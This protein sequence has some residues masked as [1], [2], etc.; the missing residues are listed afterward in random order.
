MPTA[1]FHFEPLF[2]LGTDETSYRLLT[3]DHVRTDSF[4]G[5]SVLCVAPEA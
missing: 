5:R 4:N 2:D 3:K 1:P